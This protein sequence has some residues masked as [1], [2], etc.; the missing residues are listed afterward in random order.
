[1]EGLIKKIRGYHERLGLD[2][3]Q[4]DGGSIEADIE[5][6]PADVAAFAAE[7][8]EFCPDIV[9]QGLE[10]VEALAAQI[11]ET[12]RLSLWWD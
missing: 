11:R 1:M 4:A 3:W 12:K 10:T 8:Y 7:V 5:R 9:E 2:I 6:L